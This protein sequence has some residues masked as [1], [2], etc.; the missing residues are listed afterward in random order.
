[1]EQNNVFV[2]KFY[3]TTISGVLEQICEPG[4]S[5]QADCNT[6]T[7]TDDGIPVCTLAA[8]SPPELQQGRLSYF[9]FHNP[10]LL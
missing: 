6:C 5:W 10:V 2:L 7:C 1:M 8:C 9:G 3:Y 4:T